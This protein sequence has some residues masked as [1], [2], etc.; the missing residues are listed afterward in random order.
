[1]PLTYEEIGIIEHE[2]HLQSFTHS[3]PPLAFQYTAVGM[4]QPLALRPLPFAIY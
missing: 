2:A 1:M 4:T 3:T